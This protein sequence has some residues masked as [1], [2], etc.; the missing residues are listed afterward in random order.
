MSCCHNSDRRSLEESTHNLFIPWLDPNNRSL[1]T[2]SF[3]VTA[4]NFLTHDPPALLADR[5]FMTQVCVN[6]SVEA[7]DWSTANKPVFKAKKVKNSGQIVLHHPPICTGSGNEQFV[8]AL[9]LL[10]LLICFQCH[11]HLICISH[12]LVIDTVHSVLMVCVQV[13]ACL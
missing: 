11:F 2:S 1:A 8:F 6:R 7:T 3:D 4:N 10:H 13:I 9:H 5:P 12:G